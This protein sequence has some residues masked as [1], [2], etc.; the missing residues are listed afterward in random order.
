VT[1]PPR[2][3]PE[4]PKPGRWYINP[5]F[6][7]RVLCRR[8]DGDRVYVVGH[9]NG[10]ADKEDVWGLKFFSQSFVPCEDLSKSHFLGPCTPGCSCIWHPAIIEATNRAIAV[11]GRIRRARIRQL[12]RLRGQAVR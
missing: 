5:E 3:R 7:I 12:Q 4:P 2:R 1:K 9:W 10:T 8:V 11:A 6:R